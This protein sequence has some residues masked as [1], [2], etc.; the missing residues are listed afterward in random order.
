MSTITIPKKLAG[1]DD[2]IVIP[3]SEYELMKSQMFPVI[4]MKGK[5]AKHIDLRVTNALRAYRQN[6]TKKIKSLADLG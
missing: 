6:K 1:K 2:L 3:K 4:Y 5:K